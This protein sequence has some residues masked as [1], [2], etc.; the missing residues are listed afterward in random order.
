MTCPHCGQP[1]PDVEDPIAKK[2]RQ[3]KAR[4]AKYRAL[5]GITTASRSVTHHASV[6]PPVVTHSSRKVTRQPSL[7]APKRSA[8]TERDSFESGDTGAA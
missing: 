7:L 2:R 6:T 8:Y 4:S 1:M 3:S 5:K